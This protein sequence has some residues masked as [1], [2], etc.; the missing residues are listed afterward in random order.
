MLSM[1]KI[2]NDNASAQLRTNIIW[3]NEIYIIIHDMLLNYI[4]F[5]III[6]FH[7]LDKTFCVFRVIK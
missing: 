5:Y 3:N 6:H 2:M 4:L 1:F 7:L